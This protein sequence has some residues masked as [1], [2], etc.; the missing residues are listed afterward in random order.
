MQFSRQDIIDLGDA[1]TKPVRERRDILVNSVER[2]QQTAQ[3]TP[4]ASLE[5][6]PERLAELLTRT[7]AVA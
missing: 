5:A 3:A 1:L 2:Q 4:T 7:A 6:P